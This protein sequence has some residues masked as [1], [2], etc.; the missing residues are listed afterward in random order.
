MIKIELIFFKVFFCASLQHKTSFL[1]ESAF[2][3]LFEGR[4][5][6]ILKAAISANFGCNLSPNVY[7]SS[8]TQVKSH[9]E[10]AN[11]SWFLARKTQ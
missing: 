5:S 8:L 6:V 7:A 10:M 3:T 4:N 11:L 2:L 1:S 9:A